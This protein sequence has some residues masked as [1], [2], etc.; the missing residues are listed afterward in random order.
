MP[1]KRSSERDVSAPAKYW[2]LIN[3]YKIFA[4]ARRALV[5]VPFVSERCAKGKSMFN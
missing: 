5:N 2:P 1:F 3:N 4:I